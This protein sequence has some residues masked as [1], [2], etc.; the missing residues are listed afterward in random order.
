MILNYSWAVWLAWA[1]ALFF[2]VTGVLN[3]V[4]FKSMRGRLAGRGFPVWFAYVKGFYD[5]ATGLAIAWL[6]TRPLGLLLSLLLCIAIW[7][8]LGFHRD[9]R[10][11]PPLLI[12]LVV[13]LIAAWG[14]RLIPIG[15][16]G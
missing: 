5:L 12:L 16:L 4:G 9:W 10:R 13:T 2:I 7:I 8:V 14:L 11:L 15:V 1:L 6:P 3:L